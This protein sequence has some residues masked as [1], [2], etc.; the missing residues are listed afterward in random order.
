[1]SLRNCI[2]QH[3]PSRIPHH[4]DSSVVHTFV[5]AVALLTNSTIHTDLKKRMDQTL[6]YFDIE[7]KYPHL[8]FQVCAGEFPVYVRVACTAHLGAFHDGLVDGL[9]GGADVLHHGLGNAGLESGRDGSE[10][11]V[12]LSTPREKIGV[13]PRSSTKR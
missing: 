13:D 7:Q 9:E 5:P 6:A 8:L 4:H 3:M 11:G 12:D 1:M 10:H 2:N